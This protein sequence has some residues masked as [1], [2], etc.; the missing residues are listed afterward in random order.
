M[1]AQYI[2]IS[3]AVLVMIVIL[4]VLNRR[5]SRRTSTLTMLGMTMVVLGIIFADNC[6]VGYSLIAAGVF[7]SIVDAKYIRRH[8]TC[9]PKT[10]PSR[11]S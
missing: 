1:Q 7:L 5:G 3:I 2:W 11:M 9:P 6:R 10:I 4:L 8:V